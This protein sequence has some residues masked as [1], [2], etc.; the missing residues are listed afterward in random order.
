MELLQQGSPAPV[1]I[2]YGESNVKVEPLQ[3]QK[4]AERFGFDPRP[5]A[6]EGEVKC[7]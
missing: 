6:P 2:T 7:A 1:W 4:V 3:S 5:S